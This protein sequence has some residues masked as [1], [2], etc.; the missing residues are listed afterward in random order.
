MILNC[1]CTQCRNARKRRK[2]YCAQNRKVRRRVT[3]QVNYYAL[4]GIVEFE[5][6]EKHAG[7]YAA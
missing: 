7:I 4:R 6:P 1:L 3:Q 5:I 2:D